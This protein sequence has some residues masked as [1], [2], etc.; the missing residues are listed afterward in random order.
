MKLQ[1]AWICDGFETKVK[2]KIELHP[3]NEG[4]DWHKAFREAG[5]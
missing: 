1:K 3:E 4:H 2:A 5:W